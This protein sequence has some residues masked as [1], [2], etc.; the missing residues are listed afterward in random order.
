MT[1]LDELIAA[2]LAERARCGGGAEVH[3]RVQGTNVLLTTEPEHVMPNTLRDAALAALALLVSSRQVQRDLYLA[4]RSLGDARALRNGRLGHR[5]V[6]R[7]V[8]RRVA[9][10][11]WGKW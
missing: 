3:V 4:S 10:K 1:T 2:A 11:A 8:T 6:R 7:A 5:L 9:S